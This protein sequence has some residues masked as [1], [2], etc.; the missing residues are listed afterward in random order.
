MIITSPTGTAHT[1]LLMNRRI[2]Q[3]KEEGDTRVKKKFCLDGRGGES[4]HKFSE[5]DR[6]VWKDDIELDRYKV[7]T[8][9]CSGQTEF[10]GFP[11]PW[12]EHFARFG[13]LMHKDVMAGFN[14]RRI[15]MK[16][17]ETGLKFAWNRPPPRGE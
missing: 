11:P 1:L 3:R 14:M 10:E 5:C 12:Y 6:K 15:V 17:A 7:C 16:F 13:H 8:R 9:C 4:L 2:R